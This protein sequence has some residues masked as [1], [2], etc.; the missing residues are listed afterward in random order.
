[1][2]TKW[3]PR[4]AERNTESTTMSN[5]CTVLSLMRLADVYLMYAEAVAASSGVNSSANSYSLSAL[6]AINVV[7]DRAGV[8]HVAGKYASSLE[9]FMSELQRERAVELAYE[10]HRFC[11]LRRWKLL[12]KQPYTLK[13]ALE[14]ERDPQGLSG[15][16]LAEDYQ[17]AKVLNLSMTTIF[18]RHLTSK[19]YWFPFLL[20][21]INL[22]PEFQQNPGW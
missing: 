7:R 16:A 5:N 3:K 21:D 4:L 2:L 13:Q 10:G 20:D 18:E 8:G 12:D 22:Y 19:H 15:A 17:N 11:D 1:M 14:F 9:G 6:E